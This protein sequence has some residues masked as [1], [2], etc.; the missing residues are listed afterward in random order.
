MTDDTDRAEFEAKFAIPRGL[1]LTRAE[2]THV[3]VAWTTRNMYDAWKAGRAAERER[4]ARLCDEKHALRSLDGL[5]REA[6]TARA[7]AVAIRGA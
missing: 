2:R 4:C 1:V 6:S 5:P 3:Y 7:L